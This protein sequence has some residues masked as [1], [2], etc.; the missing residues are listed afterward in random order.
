MNYTSAR[1]EL[2]ILRGPDGT[3]LVET[4]GSGHDTKIT[5]Y[6]ATANGRLCH[7]TMKN[8]TDWIKIAPVTTAAD[9]K[10]KVENSRYEIAFTAPFDQE[11]PPPTVTPQ[12]LAAQASGTVQQFL[13]NLGDVVKDQKGDTTKMTASNSLESDCGLPA[14]NDVDD[15][16]ET[17]WPP[18]QFTIRCPATIAQKDGRIQCDPL[19]PGK[20]RTVSGTMIRTVVGSAADA[21]EPQSWLE[22]SPIGTG[23]G[24]GG[25]IPITV[26]TKW[27]LTLGQ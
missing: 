19:E 16:I 10:I 9:L 26:T 4:E 22:I 7:V 13:R 18:W 1:R 15:P 21:A 14:V 6:T 24:D 17:T 8:D 23:R 12:D 3:T 11:K 2:S 27:R 25:N 5:T 20:K